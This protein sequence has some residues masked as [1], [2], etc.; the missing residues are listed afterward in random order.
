MDKI[1][2]I[3]AVLLFLVAF[4]RLEIYFIQKSREKFRDLGR[5]YKEL[6]EIKKGLYN[7]LKD[8]KIQT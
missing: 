2:F 1:I 4:I 3:L 8:N 7:L 6:K 5:A